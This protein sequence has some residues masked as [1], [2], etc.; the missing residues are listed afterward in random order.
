M[1]AVLSQLCFRVYCL[2]IRAHR[3]NDPKQFSVLRTKKNVLIPIV[4]KDSHRVPY[5]EVSNHGAST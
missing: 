4:I 2:R 1:R 5:M 3:V